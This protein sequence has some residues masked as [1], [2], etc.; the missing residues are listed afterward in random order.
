MAKEK[1]KDKLKEKR[2]RSMTPIAE[3]E[4]P[5]PERPTKRRKASPQ[6]AIQEEPINSSA[7]DPS[8]IEQTVTPRPKS[9]VRQPILLIKHNTTLD[10]S[11]SGGAVK[12]L[13]YLICRLDP[14]SKLFTLFSTGSILD[15][16]AGYGI[17]TR[18]LMLKN[19]DEMTWPVF[20]T[21]DEHLNPMLVPQA[22]LYSHQATKL[23]D[24]PHNCARMPP[25][26]LEYPNDKFH[27]VVTITA[28]D[29]FNR[30]AAKA[31]VLEVM[32]VL[33]PNGLAIFGH[34]WCLSY[35]RRNPDE[36]VAVQ[37]KPRPGDTHKNLFRRVGMHQHQLMHNLVKAAGPENVQLVAMQE[38]TVFF[39][40]R[41]AEGLHAILWNQLGPLRE[42]LTEEEAGVLSGAISSMIEEQGVSDPGGWKG[43]GLSMP[44]NIV[45]VK[46]PEK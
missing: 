41:E 26:K 13:A 43:V 6:D 14:I 22:A 16:M 20:H 2:G 35:C 38:R 21:V 27:V 25:G 44:A 5:P 4:E 18:E 23:G 37:D 12:Q 17:L 15:N 8:A 46:R 29:H 24:F 39:R 3:T 31:N 9:R 36:S 30:P 40:A 28:P 34:L 33:R 10:D 7:A 1:G 32:R 11:S 45:V 42:T 19:R